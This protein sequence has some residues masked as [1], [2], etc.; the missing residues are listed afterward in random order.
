MNLAGISGKGK[1]KLTISPE[2]SAESEGQKTDYSF[3]VELK[4][5]FMLIAEKLLPFACIIIVAI[6]V[7]CIL[8]TLK[9]RK[10]VKIK[11][12][13]VGKKSAKVKSVPVKINRS[14]EFGSKVGIALKIDSP[15]IPPVVGKIVRTGKRAWK[16]EP[17]EES[18]FAPNQKLD[19][20]SLSSTVK[21]VAK[22]GSNCS[23]KFS[24]VR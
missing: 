6:L 2:L 16:I 23:V 15:N 12:E 11:L 4:S 22:D 17:K 24:Q 13:V 10:P 20:Y 18:F 3:L 1:L 14:V 21:L 19:P 5:P 7:L 8:K 9:D